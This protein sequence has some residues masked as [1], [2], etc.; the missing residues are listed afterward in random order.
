[1]TANI[2]LKI[3][4]PN[5]NMRKSYSSIHKKK[6]NELNR[7]FLSYILEPSDIGSIILYRIDG[8]PTL[9]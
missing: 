3:L 2:K 8:M 1:M 6:M 4:S 9:L 5:C 7:E